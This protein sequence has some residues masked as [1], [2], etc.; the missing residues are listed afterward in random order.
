MRGAALGLVSEGEG[1]TLQ[2]KGLGRAQPEATRRRNQRPEAKSEQPWS[3][4]LG[5]V[6]KMLGL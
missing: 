4:V 5:L 3:I 1:E 6:P 2:T